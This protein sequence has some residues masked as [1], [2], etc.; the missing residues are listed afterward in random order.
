MYPIH[1]IHAF[2][3][4]GSILN[5]AWVQN[6]VQVSSVHL[7]LPAG[8]TGTELDN[9]ETQP[10]DIMGVSPPAATEEPAIPAEK[11]PVITTEKKPVI[12]AEK[13]PVIPTEKEPVISAEKKAVIPTEK[14]PVTPVKKKH[15][16]A[17]ILQDDPVQE[18]VMPAIPENETPVSPTKKPDPNISEALPMATSTGTDAATKPPREVP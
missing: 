5:S 4:L 15:V 14:E 18:P 17:A 11:K 1:I 3:Y 8:L 10:V 16:G 6:V 12:P 13:E 7:C 9:A 2:A